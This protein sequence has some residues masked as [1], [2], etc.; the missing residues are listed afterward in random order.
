MLRPCRRIAP[1][2]FVLLVSSLVAAA[3]LPPDTQAPQ[4]KEAG[5]T[6]KGADASATG[7]SGQVS[8]MPSVMAVWTSPERTTLQVSVDRPRFF[9]LDPA[10]LT[11]SGKSVSDLAEAY[12]AYLLE[13]LSVCSGWN[14]AD[15]A[16]V[17]VASVTQEG[18]DEAAGDFGKDAYV[19]SATV[20][21]TKPSEERC[22]LA[23][24]ASRAGS[25]TYLAPR[26]RMTFEVSFTD[27]VP[28]GAV[29]AVPF[30]GM[31]KSFAG[32]P[33]GMAVSD[34]DGKVVCRGTWGW[35]RRPADL[36]ALVTQTVDAQTGSMDEA[37][38]AESSTV[39]ETASSTAAAAL[40]EAPVATSTS[41][42]V[43][44]PPESE[45]EAPVATSTSASVE[46]P[47]SEAEATPPAAAPTATTTT[48]TVASSA[49]EQPSPA[50]AA[51]PPQAPEQA[52]AATAVCPPEPVLFTDRHRPRV[53]VES[54]T[55]GGRQLTFTIVRPLVFNIDQAAVKDKPEL[56]LDQET[57]VRVLM[58]ALATHL[59]GPKNLEF[60]GSSGM[61]VGVSS[62]A[63]TGMKVLSSQGSKCLSEV[64]ASAAATERGSC[65]SVTVTE[66]SSSRAQFL[67]ASV[68]ATYQ[69]KLQYP[70][71]SS[72]EEAAIRFPGLGST[73]FAGISPGLP[74]VSQ[75]G[76]RS[77]VAKRVCTRSVVE[78]RMRVS[79]EKA[80]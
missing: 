30:P 79:L 56:A 52:A 46:A 68:S 47:E 15:V 60:R 9:N 22:R 63:M 17:R 74:I 16:S 23:P 45:V 19:T 53:I 7:S 51:E 55:D 33:S 5:Q 67:S 75:T 18:S 50:P 77:G 71:T 14:C 65:Y 48:A 29:M 34:G 28:Q 35:G 49:S 37:A 4:R 32:A 25:V 36:Q 59:S 21:Y 44:A 27:P 57:G 12:S 26:L 54:M 24:S 76:E 80:S 64:I 11:A 38:S 10:A 40:N 78:E 2:S 13:R 72:P 66:G 3:C 1:A 69:A 58:S 8:G 43:E 6:K 61:F 20:R 62:V 39:A 70:L 31:Q 41:A 73:D 42:S